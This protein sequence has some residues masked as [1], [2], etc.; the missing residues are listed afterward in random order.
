MS[1]H[2]RV[3]SVVCAA[4][5]VMVASCAHADPG[6][7]GRA[8]DRST[9]DTPSAADCAPAPPERLVPVVRRR[10]AHDPEAFTQGLV[11]V[12]GVLWESTGGVGRSG[13]RATDPASGEVLRL[14]ASP[15]G[16]FAEGLAVQADGS[17][18]QLTW[19]EGRAFVWDP[20]TLEILK[21]F[22]YRGEGWGLTAAGGRLWMS[23][24]SDRITERDPVDFSVRDV[25]TV[26]RR[27]APA[28]RLNELDWD[29]QRL[30][31]NR[32]RT[33]EILRIDP[34]CRQV[35][36]VVDASALSAEARAAAPDGAEV[37]VLNG[38]AHVPGTDRFILTGKLWPVSFE[39]TFEP[40]DGPG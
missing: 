13:L 4:V 20:A 16:V 36:G 24:G 31:A 25:W 2:R 29:G 11:M 30:W 28:D 33:D 9:A 6:A 27:G 40:A 35:D 32:W 17:L 8:A 14:T 39:V 22:S 18:V 37:D 1:G 23:D 34:V 26:R 19:T 38:I 5:M 3:R 15:S 12:D 7:P 21:E 10:L